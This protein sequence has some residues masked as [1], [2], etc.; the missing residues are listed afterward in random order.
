LSDREQRRN[1]TALIGAWSMRGA[2]SD[3][4]DRFES[5]VDIHAAVS[6]RDRARSASNAPPIELPEPLLVKAADG[7][8]WQPL[9]AKRDA[10]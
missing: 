10:A 9:P 8:D 4:E 1:T 2:R 6:A 7:A 5:V 3:L